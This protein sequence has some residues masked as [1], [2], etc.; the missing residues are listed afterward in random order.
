ME[1][2]A[3]TFSSTRTFISSWQLLDEIDGG[4]STRL[5][6]LGVDGAPS[7]TFLHS[8]CYNVLLVFA[9][10]VVSHLTGGSTWADT[11]GIARKLTVS[12]V[13]MIELRNVARPLG[14]DHRIHHQSL[15]L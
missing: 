12:G 4:D 10:V 15:S 5:E 2:G 7:T 14:P 11:G 1:R 6:H 13:R 3:R 8:T 9:R